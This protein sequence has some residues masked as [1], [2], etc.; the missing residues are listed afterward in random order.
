[1]KRS[2][3]ETLAKDIFHEIG[4]I[5]GGSA[6]T[7]LSRLISEEITGRPPVVMPLECS[8]LPD[9]FGEPDKSAMGI[10][11][12][13]YGDVSGMLLFVL[14]EP[15]VK[16]LLLKT[17]GCPAGFHA[18]RHGHR[19]GQL[20]HG[21]GRRHRLHRKR[22]LSEGG[23]QHESPGPNAVSGIELSV[24][25]SSGGSVMSSCQLR[26][27]RVAIG[28]NEDILIVRALGSGIVVCLYDERSKTGGVAY[29]L[30]PDSYARPDSAGG[31]TVRF[32]METG[33][34]EI[35]AVNNYVY[36]L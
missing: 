12:P 16:E 3:I 32:Q 21:P 18:G 14:T 10:L 15:F 28:N 36:C 26:P 17:I 23:Q 22:F 13:F 7:A 20:D 9:A 24:F 25:R 5:G 31:R 4:N 6:V 2:E 30:F 27:N 34:A 11:L 1:M 8:K 35:R 29:T 33:I 19:P